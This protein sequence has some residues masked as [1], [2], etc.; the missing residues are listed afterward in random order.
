MFLKSRKNRV[1]LATV[2][3]S[4]LLLSCGSGDP[5]DK[6][7]STFLSKNANKIGRPKKKHE[8]L[9][10]QNHEEIRTKSVTEKSNAKANNFM[11]TI[12]TYKNKNAAIEKNSTAYVGSDLSIYYRE[13]RLKDKF[14]DFD[15]FLLG[16]KDSNLLY[17][18][19]NY[20]DY[21]KEKINFKDIKPTY[22][23]LYGDLKLRKEEERAIPSNSDFLKC[24][25]QVDLMDRVKKEVYLK[26]KEIEKTTK[27]S[28]DDGSTGKTLNSIIST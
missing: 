6:Y 1:T 5:V 26:S 23:G 14:N 3:L 20:Q 16:N 11:K 28:E 7:N 21:S 22:K 25:D 8:R 10:K 13:S 4:V 2:L 17:L 12:K 9:V 24:F 19:N 18:E 15:N 27:K